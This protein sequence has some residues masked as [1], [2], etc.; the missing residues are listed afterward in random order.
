M[1]RL[2]PRFTTPF[3]LSGLTQEGLPVTGFLGP[4]IGFEILDPS[5]RGPAPAM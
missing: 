3:L 4:H 2:R 1:G 5:W